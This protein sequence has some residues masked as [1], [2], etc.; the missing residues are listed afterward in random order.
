LPR[1][2]GYGPVK[3]PGN[4]SLPI[5]SGNDSTIV[6]SG[7]AVTRI[8][9]HF[10]STTTADSAA[11]STPAAWTQVGSVA[12]NST[13]Y[14]FGGGA[15]YFGDSTTSV[16]SGYITASANAIFAIGSNDFSVDFWMRPQDS[17]TFYNITAQGDASGTASTA[18]Y[19][20]QRRAGAL[21][22]FFVP[23]GSTAFDS[24]NATV[25]TGV[26]DSTLFTH[27]MGAK[28][29][30]YVYLTINGVLANTPY[31]I[32]PT[33]AVP[34][35]PFNLSIG[36]RGE[37]VSS[38]YRGFLDEY[39]LNI[40]SVPYNLTSNTASGTTI[41]NVPAGAYGPGPSATCRGFFYA[42]N[43]DG[44]VTAFAGTQGRL[45]KLDNTTLGWTDVSKDL[46]S[47]YSALPDTFHWQFVQY[48]NL[49]I[50]VQPNTKPQSFTLGSSSQFGDLSADAN[51]P[52]AAYVA[53]IGTFLALTGLTSDPFTV[54]ATDTPAGATG[55]TA[56]GS[57]IFLSQS[58]PNGGIV[59][60]IAGGEFGVL[61]QDSNIRR[62]ILRP[63]DTTTPFQFDVLAED[64]G[65][66]APYSIIRAGQTV[67]FLANKGFHGVT[68]T[69]P[70]VPIGIAKFDQT[71]FRDY[72]SAALQ[73]IIGANDPESQRVFWAYKSGA[74]QSGLFDKI[75]VYDT[76]L[77]KGSVITNLAG[78]YLGTLATPGL[79]LDNLSLV[80]PNL[81]TM[82][83][84]L[85]NVAL[86]SLPKAALFD[87]THTL[88]LFTGANLEAI[89]DTPEVALDPQQRVRVRGL[90]PSTDAPGALL[91][92]GA[93]EHEQQAVVPGAEQAVDSVTGRSPQNVST[94]LARGRMR[95][96]AG[97]TW[98]YATGMEPDFVPVGKR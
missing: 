67:Y 66:L 80:Y 62:M 65:L 11:V 91:S 8:L 96:I 64:L 71:F 73:L 40:G 32:S 69:G 57:V 31:S 27:V 34:T 5:I 42:R 2:D 25:S 74:G 6:A 59:R 86:A 9:M 16:G 21:L 51:L 94:R 41:F 1:A 89:I 3:Q 29:S 7:L 60:G 75:I 44:S 19:M 45:W 17:T 68:G 78:E 22:A 98:T 36:R 10:N 30:N 4:F 63:G 85:D 20:F 54:K 43:T 88:S 50:A 93:R 38:S 37:N 83:F 70:V 15:A 76:V 33:S 95:I 24:V 52:Q 58:F 84:S 28:K 79:T 90:R 56:G 72:D 77:Q 14:K 87:S 39:R 13:T 12:I 81:D 26:N 92:I 97:T 48:G 23:A 18:S 46:L 47:G 53:V 49:V 61:F 35:S 82:P 55:W